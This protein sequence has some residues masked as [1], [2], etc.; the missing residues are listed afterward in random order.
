MPDSS[1]LYLNSS[2]SLKTFDPNNFAREY[3]A[4]R[5]Q[6]NKNKESSRRSVYV[7]T[8][9]SIALVLC[10][11][12][13]GYDWSDQAEEEINIALM[14]FS[15]SSSDSEIV[16]NCKK[17]LGYENYNAVPLPYTG[18]FRPPT[19]DL[20]FTG[21]DKFINKPVVENCKAKSCE[22]EP[23]VVRK[24]NDALIIE[25][26]VSDNEEGNVSQSKIETKTVRPS[27]SKIEFDKSKQ[28]EK[29]ARKT[30]KQVE[31]HR[32]NIHSP[33]GNPKN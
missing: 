31:Q 26:W 11:G 24:N 7:E 32:Q 6:D 29:T 9:T 12:L 20:S 18:N 33:R 22:E 25:E 1:N 27:I 8:S 10:D 14:A 5:N 15:S 16:D 23:K 4:P 28:Q 3:K 2:N 19:H 30:V 21:L 13:G 17:G